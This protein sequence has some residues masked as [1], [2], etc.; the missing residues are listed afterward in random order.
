MALDGVTGVNSFVV[1]QW[2]YIVNLLKYFGVMFKVLWVHL[3][4]QQPILK[5]LELKNNTWMLL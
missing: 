5:A 2:S 4:L 1:A 3:S